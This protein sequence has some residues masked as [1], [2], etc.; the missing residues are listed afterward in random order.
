MDRKVFNPN[1]YDI[2]RVS[3]TA[4][5]A[6]ITKA[7]TIAI[8][9]KEYAPDVIAKARKSLMNP[10]Q[11]LIADYSRPLLL[12]I[13]DF[14]QEEFSA[15]ETV[16]LP[17]VLLPEFQQLEE[18]MTRS[19]QVSE[20]DQLIG[21]TLFSSSPIK[22][23]HPKKSFNVLWLF[24]PI[25]LGLSLVCWMIFDLFTE[26]KSPTSSTALSLSPSTTSVPLD[27]DTLNAN[28]NAPKDSAV[29]SSSQIKS[30][31]SDISSDFPKQACGDKLPGGI[32]TWYP[33]YVNDTQ[34]NLSLIQGNYCRDA[35]RK[36]REQQ[37]IHSI[38]VASFLNYSDAE[39]FANFMQTKVGSG[40]VGDSYVYN[41]KDS[42]LKK[43]SQIKSSQ[44]NINSDFPK[45]SCGDKSP[46]GTNTWYPVYVDYTQENLNLIRSN[47]CRDALR[48]YREKKGFHSIQVASFL[49]YSD[50]QSF[51]N[52]MQKQL[53][54]GEVGQ[55]SNY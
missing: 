46:G 9:R 10:Q 48:N 14:Q 53:G 40:K 26:Q 25:F 21:A 36:Y 18:A 31:Q 45:K 43:S 33:V 37:G 50:A 1:P 20:T 42:F 7:F 17:L 15:G 51:A 2:L 22:T 6:E 32:N 13:S 12:P 39:S 8:K 54:S 29:R 3:P 5:N 38:Q 41:N 11:R 23:P 16:T 24:L 47:Y 19:H 28:S 30:S 35:F 27:N 44:L 55:S 52:F 4:S 34:E 49:N